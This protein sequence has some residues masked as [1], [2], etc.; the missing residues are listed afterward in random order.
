MLEAKKVIEDLLSS[1]NE[2][3]ELLVFSARQQEEVGIFVIVQF[4]SYYH[5]LE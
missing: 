4:H 5:S 3:K 2:Q 1:L